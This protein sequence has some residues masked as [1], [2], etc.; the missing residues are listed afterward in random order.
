MTDKIER[1]HV[2]EHGIRWP[3]ACQPCDDAAWNQRNNASALLDEIEGLRRERD[4]A[5]KIVQDIHWMARRYAD[6]RKTYAPDMFN[7]AVRPAF[8]AGW[9]QSNGAVGESQYARDGD[10][11]A[12][13]VSL[14][15]RN[16]ALTDLAE[17]YRE[18][19]ENISLDAV[20]RPVGT[21]WRADCKPTKNDRCKHGVWMYESCGECISAFAVQALSQS[22]KK[23]DAS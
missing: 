4:E 6:G 16:S 19:L 22:P 10:F 1:G 9:L 7:K 23:V 18:A 15:Q 12:E 3:H 2:C 17:R 20:P 14:E 8:E 11:D 13:W 5:R 21:H